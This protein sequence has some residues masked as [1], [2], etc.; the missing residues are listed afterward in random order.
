VRG[1]VA[2]I[3]Q[4]A[5]KAPPLAVV[6]RPIDWILTPS[7]VDAWLAR[8]GA[9]DRLRYGQGG[10]MVQGHTQQLLL[11]RAQ[12]GEVFLFQPRAKDRD[13]FDFIAVKRVAPPALPARPRPS[14]AA[15]PALAIIY[16]RLKRAALS[17]ERCPSNVQLA[18]LT[19]LT[20]PQVKWRMRKL[21]EAGRIASRVVPS[22]ID[23]RPWSSTISPAAA[24]RRP[25]SNRRWAAP[26]TLPSTTTK[27][28]FG[29]TR[30]TTPAR[31]TFATT[32]GRSTRRRLR[33]PPRRTRL[34][35]P[36]L[37]AFQ[38]GEGRQAARKEHSRPGLGRRALGQAGR[39][40]VIL[41]ENVE[42]FRTWGP[43]DE[44]EGIRSRN[45]PA[46]HSTNGAANCASWAISC[47]S[48]NCAPATMARRPSA[49]ASSWSRAATACRSSGRAD[50]R[51][52]RQ[53]EVKSGKLK[54]WRTAAEIIDWSLPCPSIFERKKPLAEKTLRRIAHGIVK[55]VLNNPQPF[56]VPI[57]HGGG[58]PSASDRRTAADGHRRASRR[59]GAIVPH[60]T[61]FRSGAIGHAVDEPLHT[62]TANSFIQT[63]GGVRAAGVV[64]ATVAPFFARTAHGDVDSKGKRRGKG[65]HTAEEPFPTISTSQDS[66]VVQAFMQKFADNGKGYDP[67]RTAAHGHGRCAAACG[68]RRAPGAVQR[69]RSEGRKLNPGHPPT[70]RFDHRPR[71]GRCRRSCTSN[72]V[73]LR[74][75]C[76]HGQRSTNRWRRSARRARTSPKSAPSC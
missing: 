8:A 13:G 19:G 46:R 52:A 44:A 29:C 15:D 6:S 74:G 38:Q 58:E 68:R 21:I 17:G 37:Q 73:K 34:V 53:P 11:A 5:P 76:Q 54:P 31:G 33:R 1:G 27:T 60:V 72:L 59:T 20:E 48:A 3:A 2:A 49:S 66:A 28:P 30:R 9:G 12:A 42:E 40:D 43:L 64:E 32:S 24:A 10:H 45:A 71:K 69:N 65:Q 75:T 14:A 25:A 61:K 47:S 57:T 16:R 7:E 41:L 35:Q 22:A 23:P 39:P 55:F 26:S 70:N 56:I 51:Q 62:V 50:A 18:A 4:A 67:R 36:R 63:P